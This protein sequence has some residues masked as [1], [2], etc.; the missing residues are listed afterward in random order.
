MSA[1]IRRIA[2]VSSQSV[3]ELS[4]QSTVRRRQFNLAGIIEAILQISR[5]RGVHLFAEHMQS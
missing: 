2:H 5:E 1:L 4:F 3:G